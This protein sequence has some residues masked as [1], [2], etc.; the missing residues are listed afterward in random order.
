MKVLVLGAGVVGVTCAHYL[1]E[2]G[3][4]VTVVDRQ[5]GPALETS[6]ANAGVVC[7]SYATPWA[8]QEC[9]GRYLNGSCNPMRR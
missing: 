6:R 9:G 3:H 7:P 4:E 2:D 1:A 8:G 5:R